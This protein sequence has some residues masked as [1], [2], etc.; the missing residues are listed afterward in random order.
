[1]YHGQRWTSECSCSMLTNLG[2][3]D[4]VRVSYIK[5]SLFRTAW[6]RGTSRMLE[7]YVMKSL[8]RVAFTRHRYA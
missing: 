7:N 6:N 5:L 2:E 8:E 3:V 4:A 1:M